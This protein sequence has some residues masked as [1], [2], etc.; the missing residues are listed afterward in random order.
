MKRRPVLTAIAIGAMAMTLILSGC[1]SKTAA[2][3]TPAPPPP[4]STPPTAASSEASPVE[5]VKQYFA[6]T[7]QGDYTSAWKL[8]DPSVQRA[9][10]VTGNEAK[11][12]FL[13]QSG[14]GPKLVAAGE[15]PRL[16]R[17]QPRPA[18]AASS[19]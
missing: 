13:A 12:K 15:G 1:G 6:F 10:E 4:S 5:V 18:G 3:T 7:S 16:G 2:P 19:N 8:I 9:A 11:K 14:P 17:R